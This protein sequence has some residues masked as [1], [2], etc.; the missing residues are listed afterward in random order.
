M[1][2][3]SML[4]KKAGFLFYLPFFA[5]FSFVIFI[6]AGDGL[7][8]TK[9]QATNNN[10]DN[11]NNNEIIFGQSATL[12]GHLGVYG[13]FIK[14]AINAYF[15]NVNET[16]GV[17][18]KKLKLASLDDNGAPE[19]SKRN[20][21]HMLKDQKIDM[22][23]G[24]TGTRSIMSV[25]P[26]IQEKKIAMF[27]PWG[28]NESLRNPK[29]KNIINGLGYLE[30]Q[31]KKIAEYV[32]DKKRIKKIAIFHA[33]DNFSTQGAEKLKIYLKQKYDITPV[34]IDS[35][36]RLTVDIL[37]SADKLLLTD[38]KAVICIATSMP[39]AKLIGYFFEKGHYGTEFIGVDSTLFVGSI[40][41]NKGAHFCYTSCVPD[42]V[43]STLKIAQDYR[44]D[45]QK[46]FP[47]DSFN[48]LSFAYYISAR[49]LVQAIQKITGP[50]TKESIIKEIEQMKNTDID[51]FLISFDKSNRHAFGKD[52][53]I[54]KTY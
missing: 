5:I 1:N 49:I 26:L 22:F 38:P 43:N 23:F 21:K 47:K 31:I 51:G 44:N 39:T 8:I 17:N 32:V 19:L 35:Y 11:N 3:S 37:Q 53:S 45:L 20:I 28:G 48:I 29:I 41:K 18:G 25:F 52:V 30:P 46:Y 54:I 42:P 27:F 2:I 6:N 14:N 13:D 10:L 36:N 24:C 9:N 40:L 4:K 15:Y 33:D 7:N 12:S 16:G 34:G 50:I